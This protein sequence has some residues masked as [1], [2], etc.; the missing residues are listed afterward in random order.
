MSLTVIL[1]ANG[2]TPI[3]LILTE[4]NIHSGEG[5]PAKARGSPRSLPAL[6]GWT[7]VG[8]YFLAAT[9]LLGVRYWLLPNV[10]DYAGAVERAIS[11]TL[12]ERVTI[13]GIRAAWHGLRP[14]LDLTDLKIHDRE[15]RVVLSLPSVEATVAWSSVAFASIHFHSLAFDRP[16]LEIRRDSSDRLFVAG[17]QLKDGASGQDMSGW[18]LSQR[19]I[20]IRNARL[21]WEDQRRAATTLEFTGVTLVLQNRGNL[22]RFA[23]RARTDEDLASTLDVRGELRGGSFDQLQDWTGRLYAELDETD[24]AAWQRWFEFPLEIRAGKGGIR[25]WL[26]FSGKQL[27]EATADVALA[28]V[29]ARLGQTLP[30]LDLEYLE[31]R[32]GGRQTIAGFE[33]LGRKLS[34]KT[35]GGVA[36]PPADFSVRWA[37][38]IA[39]QS[40]QGEM[41][42]NALELA[43][44]AQ[45]AEFLPFP[46]EVRRQ[47]A[48]TEPHGKVSDLKLTWAGD[49]DRP[50][51]YTA[52]GRFANLGIN[53]WNRLP[54]FSGLTGQFDASDKGGTLSL[55]AKNAAIELRG[56]LPENRVQLDTL[57]GQISWLWGKEGLEMKFGN[58]A[59]A[60]KDAA[61]TFSGSYA[62]DAEGPGVIDLTGSIPR[63]QAASVHRYIPHLP[64]AVR[65]YLK[66][67]LLAGNAYDARLRLKGDLRHFPFEDSKL[68]SFQVVGKANGVELNYAE[69]WPRLTDVS[70]ELVFEG[71]RMRILASRGAIFGVRFSNTRAVI[72]NLF[73]R[74]EMLTVE[75]QVEGPTS[76]LLRFVEASPV[77]GFI[78]GFTEGIKATGNGRVQLKLDLPI[79]RLQQTRVAGNLQLLGNQ[80]VM[81]PDVPAFSL[82]SGRLDFTE[83]G[84]SARNLTSQFLGGTTAI[85]I[86]TL[87]D[88]TVSLN[89]QGT[90]TA[91]AARR[92]ADIPLLE[93]ASGS[94]SWR[95]SI[96]IRGRVFELLVESSLQGLALNLP[97]PLGKTAAEP[98][99]MRIARTNSVQSQALQRFQIQ[100]L[101]PRGDA[102]MISIG[103]NLNGVIVRAR[104]GERM[105]VDRGALSFNERTPALDRPGIVIA[106]S[107]PYLDLD[108][109]RPLLTGGEGIALP[110]AA[111]NLDIGVLDFAGRRIDELKLRATRAKGQW[112]AN[113]DARE[114]AG[115]IAWRP[116]G[117]G[118]IVARLRHLTVPRA[119]PDP[120]EDE[121]RSRE[122]PSLDVT[123]DRFVLG[124]LELGRLELVAVNEARDWRIE[125]L[126]LATPESTLS[127]DGYWQSWAARPS[128]NLNLK[129]EVTDAG[130]YLER[131]G[132][133]GTVRG[134]SAHLE[135]KVGWAAS[136]QTIDYPTLTGNVALRVEKGQFLK[137]DPGAAKLL[138]ILSLQSLLTFDL[139]DLFSEGFAFDNMS[140]TAQITKGVLTTG[141]F[142]MRG[143]AARVGLT[144]DIDLARESQKLRLRVV[145]SLGDGAATAATLLLKINPITGL[146]AFLAQRIL[147]DPLG[148]IF[149]LEYTVTGN[150]NEPKVE[151]VQAGKMGSE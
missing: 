69:S 24:L 66:G 15:G 75:G 56:I 44:L 107:L 9:L 100:R 125:R 112:S 96:S 20:V 4:S 42:A 137:A 45:L 133:P 6:L 32:L 117:R 51:R 145:P 128:T 140:G 8:A 111:L 106:G 68:G 116:E 60:N 52:R 50:E 103:R 12:G 130:K 26:G 81:G 92:L 61:G 104:D 84:I 82:V 21:S 127:A 59:L 85:S 97:P 13:G 89:A 134:G 108:H 1:T 79:R 95:G 146:G 43:P 91:A 2:A 147:K 110:L 46:R 16:D 105:V 28:K 135:G 99:A 36:L 34:L 119:A 67:A 73:N 71:A 141:D 144:G 102:V 86:A 55:G 70:G 77:T 37:R 65:N 35:T 101:P 58:L 74:N 109:W 148:Q 22:H 39:S 29:T 121:A 40:P 38:R 63:V 126:V 88:G 11:R 136:P 93:R 78:D 114:L 113:V 19:E 18:L 143:A 25:I 41:E 48:E 57:T 10:S 150:W 76:D 87:A 14:E 149:A 53:A 33:V 120:V 122:L 3:P 62:A 115:D 72:P 142:D 132:Y 30:L 118:R 5:D 131:M 124:N 139:R 54:G 27:T 80:I 83:S 7:L 151:R 17:M 94:A 138:G 47:L 123:A 129:L 31:G 23:L 49:P 64:E 98:L 90:A